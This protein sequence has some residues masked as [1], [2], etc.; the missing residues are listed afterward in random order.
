MSSSSC[1]LVGLAFLASA[2]LQSI[3]AQ[4]PPHDSKNGEI[5]EDWGVTQ[6]SISA[7]TLSKL[8]LHSA[9]TNDDVKAALLKFNIDITK[10]GV[11]CVWEGGSCLLVKS[12]DLQRKEVASLIE[13]MEKEK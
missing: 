12:F 5:I 10:Y 4:A 1:T 11:A 2:G 7:R 8:G 13:K 6:Y 9:S 3:N